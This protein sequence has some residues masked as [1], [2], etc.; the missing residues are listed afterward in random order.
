M[1]RAYSGPDSAGAVAVV[2]IHLEQAVP[3]DG[4]S[5]AITDG[6]LDA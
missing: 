6:I 1:D 5:E 4:S 2:I 3:Q